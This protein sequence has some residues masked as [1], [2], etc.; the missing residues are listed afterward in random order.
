MEIFAPKGHKVKLEHPNAGYE[1]QQE[2]AREHLKVGEVYTVD[3][4]VVGS[5]HTT[6]YLQEVP[7]V[8]FNSV[9]FDDVDEVDRLDIERHKDFS[10]YH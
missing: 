4:T 8:A 7:G 6:V 9:L 2:T 5:C 3:H 1:Y 10:K